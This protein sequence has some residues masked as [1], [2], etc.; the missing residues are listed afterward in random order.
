MGRIKAFRFRWADAWNNIDLGY[1]SI[2]EKSEK[3]EVLIK[4]LVNTKPFDIILTERENDFIE[5]MSILKEWNN[6]LYSEP[7]A[8]DGDIWRLDY[9]YDDTVIH[10]FGSNGYPKEFP[11]FLHLLHQ[12]YHLP[13]SDIEKS[14]SPHMKQSINNTEI[15]EDADFFKKAMYF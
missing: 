2:L 10:S 15:T 14:Y 12:F 4:F 6:K 11:Y 3:G 1:D 7:W 13:Y 8:I 9:I 5:R